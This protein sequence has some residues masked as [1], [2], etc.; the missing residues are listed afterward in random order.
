M[1]ANGEEYDLTQKVFLAEK[2]CRLLQ[3]V[4]YVD[5]CK[6]T[7]GATPPNL[8]EINECGKLE[9]PFTP[10]VDFVRGFDADYF[11]GKIKKWRTS[12]MLNSKLF[13][14]PEY[15]KLQLNLN[16]YL[17][18]QQYANE[19]ECPHC[20]F[21]GGL[22]VSQSDCDKYEGLNCGHRGSFD[23]EIVDRNFVVFLDVDG[24][25]NTRTTVQQTPKG[26]QGI[27]DARVEVL[28]KTIS[29]FGGADIVLS[30]D[31][32]ELEPTDEDYRYLVSKLARYGLIIS[33]HTQD[34]MYK[35]GAGIAA[36]LEEH[37]EIKEYVILDDCRF[38]FQSYP[39]LWERLLLTE[40]IEHARFAA[41]TP[42]VETMVFLD[43]VKLF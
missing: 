10:S 41:G 29:K 38:D 6:Q 25:L 22:V 42:A 4:M 14:N 19:Y 21:K 33:G 31:W 32:K 35:R 26:Y 13:E 18:A 11:S 17:R 20:G 2:K 28:A 36:Y 40:G 37:P 16:V 7:L 24:V 9:P 8:C 34:R 39:K 30:S 15:E 3:N 23:Q 5:C 1:V 12:N 27:D 43:Y